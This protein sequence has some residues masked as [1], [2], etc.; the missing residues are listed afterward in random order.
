[1]KAIAPRPAALPAGFALHPAFPNPFN[2]ETALRLEVPVPARVTLA[3]YDVAGRR[4]RTLLDGPVVAGPHTA[5]WDG[6]DDAGRPVASGIY[7]AW[8]RAPGRDHERKMLLLR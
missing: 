5:L 7:V 4:V 1:M 3:I 2:P 6:R 8:L